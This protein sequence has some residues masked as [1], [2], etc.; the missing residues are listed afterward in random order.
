MGNDT[1]KKKSSLNPLPEGV[2]LPI[3]TF[4][5]HDSKGNVLESQ[6]FNRKP[7]KVVRHKG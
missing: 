2:R 7:T 3:K 5:H 6:N 1:G 4:S